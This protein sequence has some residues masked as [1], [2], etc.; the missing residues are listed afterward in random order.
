M[1][2]V[3]TQEDVEE[4]GSL[5]SAVHGMTAQAERVC[6]EIVCIKFKSSNQQKSNLSFDRAHNEGH[7]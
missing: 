4:Y 7:Q 1:L 5:E 3:V 2:V 6:I